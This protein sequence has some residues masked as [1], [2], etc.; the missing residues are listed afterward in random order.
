MPAWMASTSAWDIGFRRSRPL[1]S[2]AKQGPICLILTGIVGFLL[3][4]I[5]PV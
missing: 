5:V 4:L 1:T 3:A 2:P